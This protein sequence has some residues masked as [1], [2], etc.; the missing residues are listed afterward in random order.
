MTS[1]EIQR[2]IYRK[3][4]TFE[5]MAMRAAR[6]SGLD[7][8]DVLQQALVEALREIQRGWLEQEVRVDRERQ[9]VDLFGWCLRRAIR[10]LVG[11]EV[12]AE[13]AVAAETEGASPRVLRR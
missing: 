12:R 11:Q 2:L 10:S 9:L 4:G 13:T 3:L 1:A 8:R 5:R 7:S 6:R